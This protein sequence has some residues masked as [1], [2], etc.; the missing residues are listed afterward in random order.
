MVVPGNFAVGCFPIYLTSFPNPDPRAYD[1]KG[2]L[3]GLNEF[4]RS[5]NYYLQ[6]ALTLVR[7][8]FPHAVILYADYYTAF[9][10]V[11]R[12]AQPLGE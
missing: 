11:L 2:C 12:R 8:E 5:H 9:Q 10:L 7:I 6:R 4:A 1:D 3:R